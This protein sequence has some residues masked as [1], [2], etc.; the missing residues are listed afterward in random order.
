L[1]FERCCTRSHVPN[2]NRVAFVRRG[3]PMAGAVERHCEHSGVWKRAQLAAS[4]GVADSYDSVSAERREPGTVRGELERRRATFDHE[5][6]RVAQSIEIVPFPSPVIR[7]HLLKERVGL[8]NL[9]GPPVHL[10]PR[11]T[12]G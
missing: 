7:A 11:D 12:A 1:E 10:S 2:P 3:E 8:V 4:L 6:V 5:S 9:A